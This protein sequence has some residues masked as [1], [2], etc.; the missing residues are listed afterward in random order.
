MQ[1]KLKKFDCGCEWEVA[2]DESGE[3]VGVNY[4]PELA[5][6]DC[7]KVW[8]MLQSGKTKGIFQ[9]ETNLGQSLAKQCKP[10]NIEEL[11][12]L[13]SVG[14]P[15]TAEAVLDGKT[16]KQRYID[17]KNGQEEV[18]PPHPLLTEIL[19]DTQGVFLFQEQAMR[20]A[21]EI[22]GFSGTR[23]DD[24]RRGIG[25]K[26]TEVIAGLKDEFIQGCQEH[27]RLS[28]EEAE[29]L[30]EILEAG[31]RY[32][33]NKCLHKST[34]VIKKG[35]YGIPEY[36]PIKKVQMGDKILGPNGYTKVL[37]VIV[38]K[39][40]RDL[41]KVT[42]TNNAILICSMEHEIVSFEE[43]LI[44]LSRLFHRKFHTRD[45][46]GDLINIKKMEYYGYCYS[47]DLEVKSNNHTFYANG[48]AVKNSHGVAYAMNAYKFSS[49]CKCHF[50]R[51][52]FL[53]ELEYSKGTIKENLFE[54][55][56]KII[57]DAKNFDVSICGPDLRLKNPSFLLQDRCIYYGLSKVKGA[58]SSRIKGLLEAIG[59]RD[60]VQLNWLELL[61]CLSKTNSGG[62]NALI[63]TGALDF[64]L[65]TR[66]RMLF[67]LRI[68]NFLT[69]EQ[70][71]FARTSS[72]LN[73]AL[74]YM[75]EGGVGKG[76][77]CK[78]SRSLA[79]VKSIVD[80]LNNPPTS[81]RD[82][83]ADLFKWERDLLGHPFTCT[84][85][86]DEIGNCT[87]EEFLQRKALDIYHIPAIIN[88]VKTYVTKGKDP[89]RE[90]AFVEFKDNTQAV[91]GVAFPDSWISNRDKLYDGNKAVLIGVRGKSDS[92]VIRKV[93]QI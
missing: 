27:S 80:E 24:L 10:T 91:K 16:L 66:S 69:E 81:L 9:L 79:K 43:G 75:I 83:K 11:A 84:E 56:G 58:G 74:S 70:Q 7:P 30:F 32:S 15:G 92:F 77:L 41:V 55:R 36:I 22:A 35:K 53:A 60:V 59:D 8:G 64:T 87:C 89:G 85:I 13:I 49:Y 50:P 86:D 47:Y 3:I 65:L 63:K 26:K 67:E 39:A 33:F 23:A 17:R 68:F 18:V 37:D 34:V 78:V 88:K 52:F 28:Q 42:W 45:I 71:E 44:A 31:Q 38:G 61:Y 46:A 21:Q 82:S 14:R 48:I 62:A 4:E 51:M 29:K 25:K 57:E 2:V 1:K 72:S 20:A 90:M 40:K 54:E 6:L 73:Q 76:Q 19:K 5:P 93:L 12:E